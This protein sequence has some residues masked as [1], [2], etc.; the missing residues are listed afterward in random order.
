MSYCT[1]DHCHSQFRQLHEQLRELESALER[2]KRDT[3][4]EV[5]RLNRRIDALRSD[6]S[7]LYVS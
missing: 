1:C 7:D 6:V 5:D 2:T 3:Q 4:D